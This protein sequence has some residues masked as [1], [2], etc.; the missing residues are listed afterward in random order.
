MLIDGGVWLGNQ[1]ALAALVQAHDKAKDEG[2]AKLL[3]QL[4]EDLTKVARSV[5]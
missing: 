3:Q 5:R 4:L 2:E 1:I